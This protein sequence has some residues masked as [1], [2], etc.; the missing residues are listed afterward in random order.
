MQDIRTQS[1]T[2]DIASVPAAPLITPLAS[3]VRSQ[4]DTTTRGLLTTSNQ[5]GAQSSFNTAVVT[6]P[7]TPPTRHIRSN[8][9][10]Q[11]RIDS[12]DVEPSADMDVED[13]VQ[14]VANVQIDSRGASGS[15]SNEP[16]NALSG[17]GRAGTIVPANHVATPTPLAVKRKYQEEI[18]DSA[19]AS[20]TDIHPP[21]A[22][23][24]ES[25]EH[26]SISSSSTRSS[27]APSASSS[28][29]SQSVTYERR[30]KQRVS[31]SSSSND[32]P[33][34]SQGLHYGGNAIRGRR[35]PNRIARR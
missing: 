14:E 4:S 23:S 2:S 26:S 29:R 6:S 7:P 17:R 3:G 25:Q 34:E 11:T 20:D 16:S 31:D 13:I 28:S 8:E 21:T 35:N 32:T 19:L 33:P 24:M 30:K 9:E 10:E 15:F 12:M 27:S 22:P 1:D 5:E 18:Q